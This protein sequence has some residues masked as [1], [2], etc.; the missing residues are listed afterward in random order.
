MVSYPNGNYS[1]GVLDAARSC[2]FELGITVDA[3]SSPSVPDDAERLRLGR[4]CFTRGS[5]DEATFLT[6]RA[7]LSLRR[8]AASRRARGVPDVNRG[9]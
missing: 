5:A 9:M 4:F 1:E 6:F 8:L 2:G 3:R 7:P